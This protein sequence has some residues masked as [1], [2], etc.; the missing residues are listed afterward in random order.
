MR[1]TVWLLSSVAL[2]P[3]LANAAGGGWGA[4]GGSVAVDAAARAAAAAALALAQSSTQQTKNLS[5]LAN[6]SIALG[7]LGGIPSSMIGAP[8][9]VA[10]LDANRL[11]PTAQIPFGSVAKTV[12]D[13]G[14]LAATALTAN[15]AVP[16]NMI[17]VASGVASLNGSKL[18]TASQIPF[19]IAAG[20]VADGGVLAATSATA[21]A[22][23]PSSLIGA[24]SGVAALGSNKLL[25]AS[26][27]PFGTAA[28]TVADGG[29]LAATSATA[30]AAI[31]SSLIGAASGVAALGANKL[32]SSTEIPFGTAAGTVADGGALAVIAAMANAAIPSSLI[33]AASGVA[34]LGSN[35]LLTVSQIP[36]GTVSGTVA[37]GGTLAATFATA[38]AAIPSSLIGAASGVA[39]LGTTKL[40]TASEIPF[41]TAA[42]TVADGGALAATSATAS[43]AIP[44]SLIGAASGVAALGATKLLTTSEIPFGTAAGTVADGGALAVIAAMANAAIPS[45]LI[46]A[47]SGVA[48]LGSNKLLTVSEIPFG[49]VSGTVADGGTLAATSVTANA[50]IPSSLIGAA[51][52]VAAL[53]TTKLLTAS[54]I[55]FGT[56]AGTVADGGALAATSATANA[57]IPSSL[58][59]AASGVAALGATKLLTTSEIPFGT[60]AGTV[61]DGGALAVIAAMAN[62]AIPSSLIGAASGVAALGSNKLLTASEIPFGTAAGTVADGG[63]LAVTTVVAN[64]AIPSS[65]I[66]AAS[67]VAGLNASKVVPA[68]QIPFGTTSGTVADG[69][70]LATTTATAN[71]AVSSIRLGAASGVATLDANKLILTAQVPF[72]TVFGSVAD[73]GM[74]AATTTTANA[75]LPSSKLGVAA[76]AAQLDAN[77]LVPYTQLP[78]GT[79]TNTVAD[80]GI[81]ATASSK[82]ASALQP[83]AIGS[84]VA[85]YND[86]RI[87]GA[88]PLASPVFTGTPQIATDPAAGDTSKDIVSAGWVSR[89]LSA[90]GGTAT[91]VGSGTDLSQGNITP[92][93]GSAQS[94]AAIAAL[95]TGAVQTGSSNTAGGP[96]DNATVS[97]LDASFTR[98]FSKSGTDVFNMAREGALG[99]ATSDDATLTRAIAYAKGR[100]ASG[101]I[102][103]LPQN[104]NGQCWAFNVTKANQFGFPDNT[105]FAGAGPASTCITW[106]DRNS[107]GYVL[108]VSGSDA[109]QGTRSKNLEFRDFKIVGSWSLPDSANSNGDFAGGTTALLPESVDGLVYRN[110]ESDYSGGFGYGTIYSSNVMVIDPVINYSRYDGLPIWASANALV[111]GGKI[112]HVVDDCASFHSE[113]GEPEGFRR[114]VSVIGLQCFDT[115]AINIG[116]P[117]QIFLSGIVMDS[118]TNHAIDI[119]TAPVITQGGQGFGTIG[120][121]TLDNI[122]IRNLINRA[123]FD[124]YGGGDT[125]ISIDATTPQAGTLASVP[126]E[127]IAGQTKIIDPYPYSLSNQNVTTIP[128]RSGSAIY[129]NNVSITRTI[130]ATN[131]TALPNWAALNQGLIAGD[132]GFFNPSLAEN[133]MQGDCVDIGGYGSGGFINDIEMNGLHCHGMF[134]GVSVIQTTSTGSNNT[135]V[136]GNYGQILI[137]DSDFYDLTGQALYT[138]VNQVSNAFIRIT[139]SHFNMD[140]Y[141]KNGCRAAA[142]TSGLQLA[143]SWS[144]SSAGC[145][146]VPFYKDGP[147]GVASPGGGSLLAYGN[148]IMNAPT[149]TNVDPTS[150]TSQWVFRDNYD[151]GTFNNYNAAS[152]NAAPNYG[153][154]YPHAAGF[155]PI[156]MDMTPGDAAYGT[157]TSTPVDAATAYPTTGTWYVGQ[158]VRNTAPTASTPTQGWLRVTNG[159][160]NVLG[161]DWIAK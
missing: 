38:N 148:T 59:G 160:S 100:T 3:M 127:S 116:S 120:S 39:A 62:A 85:A 6:A 74:L 16:T 132:T 89:L 71:A 118:P 129:L 18:L 49:T 119:D 98:K 25:T 36:F 112:S 113:L 124:Q 56:A 128:V 50:A 111:I 117:F 150:T 157:I 99:D 75:A 136:Q 138:Y 152:T 8:S 43:A 151:L 78:F 17:G 95:A 147:N 154:G 106:N 11:V 10:G 23:I 15:A 51:S 105:I 149:E 54:E 158:F 92:T 114:N 146:S 48:A 109:G 84:T 137:N 142:T 82:A 69:G 26:E 28:G 32:L 103:Y 20:T 110:V 24:A 14:I 9:G 72:G 4:G 153:I 161:T 57:A 126:G 34:A 22:A 2:L 67:G 131:T 73:G 121:V 80:G 83:A 46:G 12:A 101:T 47:A 139:N 60:A 33:G 141:D 5:D 122:I 58:I 130:G 65:L 77:K 104:I 13:G 125:A 29:A 7:N 96:L 41:G 156:T 135:P 140:P 35:K 40:L 81:L 94:A 108:F 87:T 63:A 21:S 155:R 144:N 93:G 53:G 145:G 31:P 143:G 115:E 88:A 90:S 107:G 123:T 30:S 70:S 134:R 97:S 52:G 159:T 44:S 42:G 79:T 45:S 68:A 55:P 133:Q 76:G 37:D 102:I 66:G 64:A 91:A 19:G 27:I 1:R 86:T 61:A